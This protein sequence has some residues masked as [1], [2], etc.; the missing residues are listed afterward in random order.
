MKAWERNK[1]AQ[2]GLME[3]SGNCLQA[4]IAR[5]GVISKMNTVKGY[6]GLIALIC[7]FALPEIAHAQSPSIQ[8][9]NEDLRT[10]QR[11]LNDLG[12]D[13]G[14]QNDGNESAIRMAIRSFQEDNGLTVTGIFTEKGRN[15]LHEFYEVS[16]GVRID[17]EEENIALKTSRDTAVSLESAQNILKRLGYFSEN[18]SNISA[19]IMSFQVDTGIEQTGKIDQPT[20]ERLT[21]AESYIFDE[22]LPS[23]NARNSQISRAKN[24]QKLVVAQPY[25]IARVLGRPEEVSAQDPT[26]LTAAI[27]R[28][29]RSSVP[30]VGCYDTQTTALGFYNVVQNLWI[31]L[32]IDQD[33]GVFSGAVLDGMKEKSAQQGGAWLYYYASGN[34]IAEALKL[35]FDDQYRRFQELFTEEVC[36]GDS[37]AHVKQNY[38]VADIELLLEKN[39]VSSMIDAEVLSQIE[40]KTR[41]SEAIDDEF[42]L[43]LMAALEIDSDRDYDLLSFHTLEIDQSLVIVQGWKIVDGSP[44]LFGRAAI[45]LLYEEDEA[46]HDHRQ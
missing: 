28:L 38:Q 21:E 41:L 40:E 12:Y 32:W 20:Y 34:S 8:P 33:G 3:I 36:S 5:R 27:R 29:V 7:A 24:I 37:I 4:T 31:T 19:A 13:A 18:K 15:L 43:T 10:T 1:N 25:L 30:I 22:F 23:L 42:G 45:D 16:F 11:M 39:A 46:N 35:S 26:S 17:R 14:A 9:R 2:F 6:L 44:K